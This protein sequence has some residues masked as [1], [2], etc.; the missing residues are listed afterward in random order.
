MTAGKD[1]HHKI[2]KTHWVAMQKVTEAIKKKIKLLIEVYNACICHLNVYE[3]TR[4]GKAK[5]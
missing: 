1:A 3:A 2:V 4:T 5:H